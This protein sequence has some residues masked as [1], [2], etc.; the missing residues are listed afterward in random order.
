MSLFRRDG[1]VVVDRGVSVMARDGVKLS[2]NVY[3]PPNLDGPLPVVVS[4]TP[5][6]IDNTPDR[7]GMTLMRLSGV[8]FGRLDCSRWT[9]FESPDPLFWIRAGYA[10]VQA[11][12][13]GMHKSEGHAGFLS[14]DDARDYADL[15]EWAA[16]QPWSNGA[17]GL[18]G[19]SYLCMSQWRVAA[20]RPSALRA[21]VAWEGVTDLLREFGYQDGIPE[22]GF[23]GVW[24]KFRMRRGRNRRFPMGED[25]PADRD[26]H[27]LDDEYW[28]G[29]RPDLAAI[30]VPA[31]VCG[32]WSDHGLHTR[33]SLYGFEQI[34]SR[35]KWLY[36]HGR[37]KWEVFYSAEAREA[38]RRFLDRFVK[39]EDNGWDTTPKVRLEN[40][41]T[42]TTRSVRAE[43]DWPL[44]QVQYTPLFLDARTGQLEGRP[45]NGESRIAYDS[46]ARRGNDRAVFHQVL[47]RDTELTGGMTLRL[48]VSTSAGDDLDLFVVV[49]KLDLHGREVHFFGY[50]GFRN[51]SVAKGWLRASHR[52]TDPE[53]SR[54][55]RPWHT[56]AHAEPARPGD[57]VPV[58]IEILPSSTLFESGTTLQVD[59]LGHDAARYPAFRHARTV[60][61]GEHSIY[62]GGQ[63]DSHLLIPRVPDAPEH[64][65]DESDRS[66]AWLA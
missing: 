2:A 30:Q 35:D 26:R 40:R 48:W 39:D 13:R 60:N 47:D 3:R 8:R 27:R 37:R 32:S 16:V 44:P 11:D 4:V 63:Y 41:R 42:R 5:Y 61:R 6:G 17:V 58:E 51:D 49:R 34:G 9:G 22:T 21:I 54:P 29:K 56:H 12:V 43:T 14:D 7:I 24:W 59:V 1:E 65:R 15:I 57:I 10:V 38:Q 64:R 46:T 36:T 31:L 62:T 25:F 50:N 18:C 45:L 19:V 28:Q 53:R 55:G 20:L 66:T 23:I 33:G 52:G